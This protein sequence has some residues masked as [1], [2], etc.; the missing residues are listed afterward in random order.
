MI[1]TAEFM[2]REWQIEPLKSQG[3]IHDP[4]QFYLRPL[5]YPGKF[6]EHRNTVLPNALAAR[7]AAQE[8]AGR[9]VFE[10]GEATH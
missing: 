9:L 4:E 8:A 6:P 10:S 5:L 2:R 3:L 7:H 1:F